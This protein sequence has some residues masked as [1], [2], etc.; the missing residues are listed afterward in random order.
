[1]QAAAALELRR[2]TMPPLDLSE[3]PEWAHSGQRAAYGSDHRILLVIAGAQSGK[4]RIG[5][6]LMLQRMQRSGPGVYAMVAPT[7]AL[8]E[9]QALPMFLAAFD[10]LGDYQSQRRVFAFS[11]LG[12]RRLFGRDD[13]PCT[14]QFGYAE[15]PNSLE[16][17]TLSGVWADECGQ[18]EFKRE[19]FE[20]L[21]HRRLAVK[22]GWFIATTT[23]YEPSGPLKEL[24]DRGV[25]N[26]DPEIG[27]VSFTSIENP[28]YPR[29]SW[30]KA[31]AELPEWKFDMFHR[32]RFTRPAGQVYDCFDEA[33]NKCA[34]FPVPREWRRLFG[35][36]YGAENTAT[37]MA[38]EDPETGRYFVYA[39]L[40][41]P[42]MSIPDHAEALLEHKDSV[43]CR[44]HGW[45]GNPAEEGWREAFRA[46]GVNVH[47]PGVWEVAY[48][49]QQVYR[50]FKA[51]RLVVFE[52]LHRL[53]DEIWGYS[54][55]V[56]PA[57]GERSETI[58]DKSRYHRLDALRALCVGLGPLLD[59]RT[60]STV[61]DASKNWKRP[62]AVAVEKSEAEEDFEMLEASLQGG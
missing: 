24:Y 59:P 3:P 14:I 49:I 48:G 8:M 47:K 22:R 19:T 54:Y 62:G 20:N 38:A 12:L 7:Y 35:Q 9:R 15:N 6:R 30:D 23:P 53:L 46:H 26:L 1:M 27:V 4:T 61:Y 25:Q 18:R 36:D 57:T 34:R 16:S 50:A 56:D 17:V 2:R 11:S 51:G 21:I 44:L 39:T 32:G 60:T 58:E 5:P 10:G 40:L 31:L 28:A 52:D 55:R 33:K 29:E 41:Q 13:E 43:G 45:G 42:G 37:V